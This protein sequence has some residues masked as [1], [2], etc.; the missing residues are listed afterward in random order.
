MPVMGHARMIL[1]G[2][3]PQTNLT[4]MIS[5]YS[6]LSVSSSGVTAS[7]V[8]SVHRWKGAM[9]DSTGRGYAAG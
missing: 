5:L 4:S 7:C 2:K 8:R 6:S 9:G 3:G 1:W